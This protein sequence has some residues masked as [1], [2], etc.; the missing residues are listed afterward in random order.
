MP[1]V[2]PSISVDVIERREEARKKREAAIAAG[3]AVEEKNIDWKKKPLNTEHVR[4]LADLIS[5][6]IFLGFIFCVV[7]MNPAEF[8]AQKVISGMKDSLDSSSVCLENKIK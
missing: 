5:Y 1:P 7:F 8:N 6:F 3:K 2:K 4:A